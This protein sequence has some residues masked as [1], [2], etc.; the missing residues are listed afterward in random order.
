MEM[1]L[2]H[3]RYFIAV[4]DELHFTRAAEKLRIAQPALSK[5]IRDL[6]DEVGA[7][8]LNR[9][10]R[11]ISL[12]DAGRVF[13]ERASLALQ[14]AE[15]ALVETRRAQRGETGKIAIGFFEQSGYMLLPPIL[16]AY[17]QSFPDVDVQLRWLSVTAQCD[18]LRRGDTDAA[19]FRSI[20][21]LG[22]I[23]G[24]DKLSA[25][26]LHREKFVLAIPEAH[27]WRERETVKIAECA[28]ESF[29]GYTEAFA[30]DFHAMVMRLCALNGFSPRLSLEVG[31]SYTLLGLV[32]AGTGIAFVP[33][34]AQK[35][36]FEGVLFKRLDDELPE[37]E[38]Y[39]AWRAQQPSAL[40]AAF[41]DTA[42]ARVCTNIL[43][44]DPSFI[45]T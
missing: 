21:N 28:N 23:D 16:R 43:P 39:L 4:A 27:P 29:V 44:R 22:P 9:S 20:A 1:D 18:A 26:K 6:E 36:K 32:S 37:I 10:G 14:A 25:I 34:S 42:Q 30:P 35:M 33:A 7:T 19:F 40:L 38:I 5:Q 45:V 15:S 3:M 2:R 8:L 31:Q 11:S 41:I 17:R 24:L 13:Y 12:S